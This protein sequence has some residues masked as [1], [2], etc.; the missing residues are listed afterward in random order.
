MNIFLS[1]LFGFI[2]GILGGMGMGGGTL[3]I[4]LLTIFLGYGQKLSQGINLIAFLCMA[5]ISL[6]IHYKN[7]LL[8]LHGIFYIILSGIVFSI[9]GALLA[10]FL[11]SKVLQICFGSFLILL[12]LLEIIRAIK[13]T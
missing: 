8:V 11:P 9:G 1:L 2:S 3:L 7:K 10:G 4:P 13:K 5:L 6:Y 12:S